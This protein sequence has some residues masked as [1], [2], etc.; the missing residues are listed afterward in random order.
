MG[1]S[2]AILWHKMGLG[3]LLGGIYSLSLA[4]YVVLLGFLLSRGLPSAAQEISGFVTQ[5]FFIFFI[6]GFSANALM[7]IWYQTETNGIDLSTANLYLMVAQW[8]IYFIGVILLSTSMTWGRAW[9]SALTTCGLLWFVA[10]QEVL[11]RHHRT[12]TVARPFWGSGATYLVLTAM[13]VLSLVTS[14]S[15]IAHGWLWRVAVSGSLGWVAFSIVG[16]TYQAWTKII[17]PG[18]T[19]PRGSLAKTG[20]HVGLWGGFLIGKSWAPWA[21]N[22]ALVGGALFG[23]AFLADSHRFWGAYKPLPSDVPLVAIKLSFDAYL[24]GWLAAA[25]AARG[26]GTLRAIAI[27]WILNGWISMTLGGL[28]HSVLPL[29]IEIPDNGPRLRPMTI[30]SDMKLSARIRAVAIFGGGGGL[31][32]GLGLIASNSAIWVTGLSCNILGAVGTAVM[33]AASGF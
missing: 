11:W 12:V 32:A 1:K 24:I 28:L 17:R 30:W 20:M 26:D 27:Y 7:G 9:G 13:T 3:G 31:L 5:K 25:I 16:L 19:A 14:L 23:A 15:G 22:V 6:F 21:L 33:I 4:F 2:S 29:F 8:C 18:A 10:N